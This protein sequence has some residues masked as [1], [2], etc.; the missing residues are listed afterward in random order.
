MQ[1]I[2]ADDPV[3][4]W[5]WFRR[6][7]H[8]ALGDT[9]TTVNMMYAGGAG[10]LWRAICGIIPPIAFFLNLVRGGGPPTTLLDGFREDFNRHWENGQYPTDWT[11]EDTYVRLATYRQI[12][13]GAVWDKLPRWSFVRKSFGCHDI[14]MKAEKIP[15]V[16]TTGRVSICGQASEA[17]AIEWV[18]RYLNH[19][20]AGGPAVDPRLAGRRTTA[21]TGCV[22][23][24]CHPTIPS[25]AHLN[26]RVCHK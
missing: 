8:T 22:V 12:I 15:G 21:R 17:A 18:F 3:N 25:D 19:R 20:L 1:T 24:G 14:M 10:F 2:Y 23:P 26:C 16:G 4:P 9:A 11:M 6:G 13:G 7:G 5:H